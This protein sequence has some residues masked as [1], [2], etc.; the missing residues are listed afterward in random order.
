LAL[1]R[2]AF[3]N[4]RLEPETTVNLWYSIYCNEDFAVASKAT[5]I[6]I[7]TSDFFPSHKK[8][9]EALQRARIILSEESKPKQIASFSEDSVNKKIQTICDWWAN[10]EMDC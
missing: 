7:A 4:T 5:E 3:P 1:L 8:F 2:S 9:G 6:I 10:G